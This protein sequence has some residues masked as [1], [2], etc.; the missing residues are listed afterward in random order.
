[1]PHEHHLTVTRRARWYLE[2]DPAAAQDVWYALHGY[3]QLAGEFVAGCR[4]LFEPARLVVAPEALSRYYLDRTPPPPGTPPKVGASWMTRE[5]RESE[6]ADQVEYLDALHAHVTALRGHAP[7]TLRVLGFSQG[8]ATAVRWLLAGSIVP[9]ELIIWAGN[10]PPELDDQAERLAGMRLT[11]VTG[12]RDTLV[13]W[14]N[15]E[16]TAEKLSARGLDV[17]LLRF[18]GGH[19]LDDDTLRTIAADLPRAASRAATPREGA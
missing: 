12:E 19:R 8:V 13:E 3:G 15:V 1:M 6:I 11:L 16:A 7:A 2:G 17:R 4:A 5:D 10:A 9:D 14:A 18:A